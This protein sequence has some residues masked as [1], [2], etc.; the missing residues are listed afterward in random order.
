MRNI[1]N[2]ISWRY[3]NIKAVID[4]SD[5]LLWWWYTDFKIKQPDQNKSRSIDPPVASDCRLSKIFVGFTRICLSVLNGGWRGRGRLRC[6]L[7]L[8]SPPCPPRHLLA[9]CGEDEPAQCGHRVG[10]DGVLMYRVVWRSLLLS[11]SHNTIAVHGLTV[12]GRE[13]SP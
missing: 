3:E 10:Y 7:P 2:N 4:N 9:R 1:N 8:E 11:S 5:S 6:F 12:R 13:G